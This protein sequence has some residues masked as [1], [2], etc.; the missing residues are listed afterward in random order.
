V[1]S[2]L[3]AYLFI[4]FPMAV[5]LVFTL[6]PTLAGLALSFFQWDGS[7]APR[8]V[9]L[10]NFRGLRDDP[11]FWAGLRNTLIY[12]AVTVPATVVLAFGLASVVHA[13]WFAGKTLAR[14]MLFM[15]TIVSIVAVGFVWRWLLSDQGGLVPAAVRMLGAAPPDFLQDGPWPMTSIVVVSIW[16]G[17]G[18][19]FVLYLAALANVS[20]SLYEAA[21]VD[22][23]SRWAVLRHISWPQVA[24]ITAFLLVTGVIGALQVFDVVWAITGGSETDRTNVL[25]LYVYREF[26]Q[27]RLG[28]AAAIGL[29][30]FT[31]TAAAAILPILRR[32]RRGGAS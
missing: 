14:T 21:E 25:N 20:E 5:L 28:Y 7:G 10:A 6:L 19:C 4:A 8:W 22:G 3:N 2:R 12:V 1:R 29:V 31:L 17:T 18:F 27:G 15:P 26:K 9:G 30:I 16:R 32:A 24:P 13:R 11:R 23:A